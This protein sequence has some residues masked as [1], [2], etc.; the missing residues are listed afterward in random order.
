MFQELN[1]EYVELNKF[2]HEI[3]SNTKF[4]IFFCVFLIE[5]KFIGLDMGCETF[6]FLGAKNRIEYSYLGL[7]MLI[8]L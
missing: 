3:Q 8:Q 6:F 4:R 1:N 5:K 7:L 2:I